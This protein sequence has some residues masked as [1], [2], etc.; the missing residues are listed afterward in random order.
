MA[1]TI[2]VLVLVGRAVMYFPQLLK[3]TKGAK[4]DNV[5]ELPYNM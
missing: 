2:T 1:L 5:K 4:I 3:P